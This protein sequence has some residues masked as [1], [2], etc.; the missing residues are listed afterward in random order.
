MGKNLKVVL[1][2][3]GKSFKDFAMKGDAITLAIGVIIGVAFKDLVD[4]L[5]NNIFTPPIGFLTA[6]LD[7]SQLYITLGKERFD[8]LAEAQAAN[9]VVLQ[10]GLV[11]N[12][13]ITF[14]ITAFILY[15]IV[16]AMSK[17]FERE[18]KA[19]AKTTKPCPYCLSEIPNKAKKCAYCTSVVK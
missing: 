19:E 12:A 17:A 8:T 11:L 15:L 18:K 5:V 14:I 13:I 9:A 7:F 3:E 10:Y 6:K 16:R 4:S 2:E 1:K